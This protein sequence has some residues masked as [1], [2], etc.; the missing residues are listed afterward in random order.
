MCHIMHRWDNRTKHCPSTF[1]TL[2]SKKRFTSRRTCQQANPKDIHICTCLSYT[3]WDNNTATTSTSIAVTAQTRSCH[4]LVSYNHVLCQCVYM[5]WSWAALLQ[6]YSLVVR[7]HCFGGACCF[8]LQVRR[9]KQ[10]W[11]RGMDIWK[12]GLGPGLWVAKI[13]GGSNKWLL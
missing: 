2:N 12:G 3:C 7:Y 5:V 1:M 13:Y 4:N 9:V 6:P 8:S 10:T 11:K